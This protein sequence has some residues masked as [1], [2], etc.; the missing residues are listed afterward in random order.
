MSINSSQATSPHL[1]TLAQLQ[2]VDV[3]LVLGDREIQPLVAGVELEAAQALRPLA[4]DAAYALDSNFANGAG[5]S[6]RV[7]GPQLGRDSVLLGAGF[8]IQFNERFST[9][10]YYDGELGRKDYQ[11]TSVT[12]GVRL[13]F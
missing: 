10:F 12:G 6:F 13:A 3:A 4:G 7:N 9:Y 5:D 1:T 2:H 8:A 11:S